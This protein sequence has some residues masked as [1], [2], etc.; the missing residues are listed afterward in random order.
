MNKEDYLEDRETGRLTMEG[1]YQMYLDKDTK[2]HKLSFEQFEPMFRTFI[3]R[4]RPYPD[5]YFDYW[6]EKF[7]IETK[8]ESG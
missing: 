3:L 4:H 1:A 6:D 2:P 7:G 8:K 5:D